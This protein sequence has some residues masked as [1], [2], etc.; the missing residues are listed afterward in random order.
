MRRSSPLG[1]ILWLYILAFLSQLLC[2]RFH[3]SAALQH[4]VSNHSESSK[5]QL[6]NIIAAFS[7][8]SAASACVDFGA[9]ITS[10]QY[11]TI[12]LTD[13]GRKTCEFTGYGGDNKGWS[14][15]LQMTLVGQQ[16][17]LTCRL[18]VRWWLLGQIQVHGQSW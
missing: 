4:P 5:M 15:S 1:T 11:A 17:K 2:I 16:T 10:A 9:S 12:S 13:N 3:P 6:T 8:A 7:F 14:R 18:E